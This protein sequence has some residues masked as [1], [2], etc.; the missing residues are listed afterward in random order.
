MIEPAVPMPCA[1]VE[2]AALAVQ[3]VAIICLGVALIIAIEKGY[4][5]PQ[6]IKRWFEDENRENCSIGRSHDID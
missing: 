1:A 3:G 6:D 2:M 5:I 4:D